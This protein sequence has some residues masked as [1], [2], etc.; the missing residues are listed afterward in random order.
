MP[1]VRAVLA[2]LG[3]GDHAA[4]L[5]SGGPLP[6]GVERHIENTWPAV[7]K[8]AQFIHRHGEARHAD[9]CAA[10]RIPETGNAHHLSVIRSGTW[11][12]RVTL[13]STP[14]A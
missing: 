4:P 14:T 1:E 5:A 8:L 9:V 6:R 3:S 11:P 2:G 7:V 10:L 12:A 13:P